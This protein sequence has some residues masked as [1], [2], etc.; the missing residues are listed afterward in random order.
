MGV[1]RTRTF[2][3]GNSLAVRLPKSAGL[4]AGTEVE[5]TVEGS[6]VTL[7]PVRLTPAQLMELL[8]TLPSPDSVQERLPVD[9]PERE[10]L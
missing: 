8:D 4:S 7:R 9:I 3:N 5:M 2:M 1:H 10:G 6:V